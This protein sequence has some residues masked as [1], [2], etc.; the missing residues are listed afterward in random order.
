M[1]NASDIAQPSHP[2]PDPVNSSVNRRP[3]HGPRAIGVDIAQIARPILARRGLAGA[4]I[5]QAWP[6][7]VGPVL[8]DASLPQ[9]ISKG[10]AGGAGVLT[11]KVVPGA[12][13]ELQHFAPA[14]V[15]RINRY[16]GYRA[17]ARLRLQQ[18]PVPRRPRPK[19]PAEPPPALVAAL[20]ADL[21][22]ISDP[23]LRTALARLG[24][25]IRTRAAGTG[26]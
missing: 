14:I 19:P 16:F 17:V 13:L 12:A 7:I 15:E 5:V 24:A 4:K 6:E 25:R 22:T 11:V 9:G 20:E 8:A 3:G 26:G 18:G 21:A 10:E 1:A 2:G 23:T